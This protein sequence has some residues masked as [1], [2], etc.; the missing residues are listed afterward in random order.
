MLLNEIDLGAAVSEGTT[1]T[2]EVSALTMGRFRYFGSS[3]KCVDDFTLMESSSASPSR[4]SGT[5]FQR[6]SSPGRS[7]P[8]RMA[9]CRAQRSEVDL[10][11]L[12]VARK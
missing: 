1:P 10:E 12:H 9:K 11:I 4:I 5:S 2:T 8:R 6:V 3:P 7:S